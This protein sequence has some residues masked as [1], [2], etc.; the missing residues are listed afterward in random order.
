[1]ITPLVIDPF[2]PMEVEVD[3]KLNNHLN[4]ENLL[5]RGYHSQNNQQIN[6]SYQFNHNLML[7]Q[8]PYFS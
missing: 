1:M 8:P 6:A 5:N 2:I 4:V 7:S 3:Q